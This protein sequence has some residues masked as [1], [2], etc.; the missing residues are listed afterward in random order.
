M[1]GIRYL[2]AD[3]T[4]HVVK[5]KNGRRAKEGRGAAFYYYAPN[6]SVLAIPMSTQEV[7]FIFNEITADFQAIT[8]Q[9]QL[10]YRIADPDAI[11]ELVNFSLADS[12]VGYSTDEPHKLNDRVL[13]AAQTIVRDAVERATLKEATKLANSLSGD[14]RTRLVVE[15]MI[16]ALGIDVLHASVAN[17]APTPETARALEAQ[18]REAILKEADDAIY[19]RRRAAVEQERVIAKEAEAKAFADQQREQEIAQD[20]LENERGLQ[21]QRAKLASEQL[22]ATIEAEDARQALTSL[23]AKNKREQADASAYATRVQ[24]DALA[25][26]PVENLKALT[27]GAMN[28]DQ[29]MAN[30]MDTMAQNAAKIGE[31]N[32]GTDTLSQLVK[33]AS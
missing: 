12:G 10:T 16:E 31:L 4:T 6:T 33:H 2:K 21:Q 14:L 22:Q 29:L 24:L 18:A 5:I 25:S 23:S 9:G 17:I 32:I 3:P 19:A 1:L 28:P 13:K 11:S 15:P 8:L 27:L 7:P 26:I 20:R 30:A